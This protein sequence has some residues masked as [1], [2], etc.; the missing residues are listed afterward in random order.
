MSTR[1]AGVPVIAWAIVRRDP[2]VAVHV[3]MNLVA[4]EKSPG[5]G[6]THPESFEFGIDVAD[7]DVELPADISGQP[8]SI[9]SVSLRV[10]PRS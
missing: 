3:R 2:F 6:I 8:C 7:R 5:E 1:D 9:R 10:D 4:R